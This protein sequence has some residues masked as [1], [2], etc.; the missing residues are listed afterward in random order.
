M[1]TPT[2]P[3]TPRV[4]KPRPNWLR[5]IVETLLFVA[6]FAGIVTWQARHLLPAGDPAPTTELSL[7]EGGS[8]SLADLQGKPTLLVLWAPW[9]SV[10]GAESDNVSRV[11]RWLGDRANVVSVAVDYQSLADV[12]RYVER[13][14]VDYPVMLDNGDVAEAFQLRSFPTLY[15][16]DKEGRIKRRVTGY[17]STIGMWWRTLL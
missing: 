5:R 17:T 2:K 1:A 12:Q 3:Q 9:C 10:C 16:L 6:L 15:V 13:Y 8:L 14:N 11:Q 4:E 7:F